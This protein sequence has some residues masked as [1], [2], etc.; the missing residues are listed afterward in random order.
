MR[1]HPHQ[2]IVNGFF[3][4]KKSVNAILTMLN[5][6]GKLFFLRWKKNKKPENIRKLLIVHFGGFGD[7]LL[8]TSVMDSLIEHVPQCE[9]DIMANKDVHHI[10][11]HDTRFSN[12]HVMDN[13]FGKK[14]VI[15][16]IKSVNDFRKIGKRYDAAVCLRSFLDNGVLPLYLSGIAEYIVGFST[17]GFSFAL[18]ETVPW[19]E[20]M[21]ETEHYRD[22]LKSICHNIE[23]SRP[24]I[25][26]DKTKNLNTVRKKLG[27]LSYIVVHFGSREKERTLNAKR[28][29]QVILWL[30]EKTSFH[31]VLT[32][33]ENESY[34]WER[35]NMSDP[36]VKAS[37]GE[38][39]IFA[40]IECISL[41]VSVITIDTFAAHVAA[42]CDIPVISFWSG[43][44]DYRQ[45]QP[46]GNK[47]HIMRHAVPCAPCFKP[48]DGMEC[49]HH[50]VIN[51]I[52]SVFAE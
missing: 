20:G 36:R 43:I 13:R 21:H 29:K 4:R 38:F 10:L 39:D 15:N 52:G 37:F 2:Q 51:D 30:L 25:M 47:V 3:T 48:C 41:S 6:A 14:Y 24:S 11:Q 45:W 9:I 1:S 28:S 22:V 31:I 34:L 7:A 27:D 26:R 33:T 18:D 32:G 44:N 49:M 50:N 5:F 19:I 46:I 16:L 42:M 40:F 35:L 17:G 23:I 8:L 12:F